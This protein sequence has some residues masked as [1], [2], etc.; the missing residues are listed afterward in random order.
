M[1]GG[2]GSH[3]AQPNKPMS[4]PEDLDE[5]VYVWVGVEEKKNKEKNI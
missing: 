2:G 3:K 1:K 4:G 5:Q